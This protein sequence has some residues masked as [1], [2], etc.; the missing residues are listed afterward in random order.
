MIMIKIKARISREMED[1]R[2]KLQW[3]E[4]VCKY[5]ESAFETHKEDYE[6]VANH[7]FK[8]LSTH[9]EADRWVVFVYEPPGDTLVWYR[10]GYCCTIECIEAG[11][12]KKYYVALKCFPNNCFISKKME[13]GAD[14][15][16]P[17]DIKVLEKGKINDK[18]VISCFSDLVK[19]E[20][21][22]LDVTSLCDS[23]CFKGGDSGV[24]ISWGVCKCKKGAI[25]T[26]LKDDQ[27]LVFQLADFVYFCF[28][29]E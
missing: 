27:Y 10:C 14:K 21:V 4:D 20:T 28:R 6:S 5:S 13:L 8:L 2:D 17:G 25:A 1:V 7:I 19:A 15:C 3:K 23:F 12:E 29:Q 16:L 11:T 22:E 18:D 9:Y 24:G 26:C